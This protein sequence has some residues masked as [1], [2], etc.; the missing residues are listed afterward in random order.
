M[1][2]IWKLHSKDKPKGYLP[3]VVVVGAGI[4]GLVCARILKD[5]GFD[6]LL[7][8]ARKRIG[9][10]IWTDH[11][12]GFSCD[13]GASWIHGKWG[14][15]LVKWCKR[16]SYKLLSIPSGRIWFYT[17]GDFV[18]DYKMIWN[19][20]GTILKMFARFFKNRSLNGTL[21]LNEAR[22]L[23]AQSIKPHELPL[24]NWVVELLEAINGAP[25][26]ELILNEIGI[27]ELFQS[28]LLIEGGYEKLLQEA[29]YGLDIRKG[30]VV[31][32]VEYTSRGVS[33]HTS[34]GTYG[35]E[36]GIISVPIGVLKRGIK[37]FPPLPDY[38]T[39]AIQKIGYGG[40][41]NKV[42]FLFKERFWPSPHQRL[43]YLSA[44]EKENNG[45][46]YWAD[47][48][49]VSPLPTLMGFSNGEAAISMDLYMKEEDIYETALSSLREMFG[50]DLIEPSDF[51]ITRWLSDP[52][53]KGSYSYGKTKDD[54]LER[55]TM[56]HPL[57]NRLFFTGEATHPA[58]YGT[59]HGA[60]LSG[61]REARR[62]HKLFCCKEEILKNLPWR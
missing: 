15:P 51:I 52:F 3:R 38:K 53:S 14:N 42:V 48:S 50:D 49:S 4:S 56:S 30:V 32:A 59:V 39:N 44:S 22:S 1:S 35:A 41:L 47:F 24:L 57:Y 40:V 31:E 5:S 17:K 61:E 12:L 18:P 36:L 28:N 19:Y 43:T 25:S 6:V 62:I 37:F 55:H 11:S 33:F 16:S 34:E 60:L 8:E 46:R 45:F 21:T 54:H 58:H 10:R 13:L 27:L 26:Y 7:L 23:I 20:K 2:R 9:G 29:S